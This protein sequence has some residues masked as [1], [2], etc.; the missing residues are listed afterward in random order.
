MFVAAALNRLFTTPAA[1]AAILT[2]CAISLTACTSGR[3]V[4]P[5]S[6][7]GDRYHITRA[8]LETSALPT[9]YD[10]VR[11][12]RPFWLNAGEAGVAVYLNDQLV[13]GLA[14]LRRISVHLTEEA[15]F[16]SAT[17]AQVRFGQSNG[18][19]PAI[20]VQVRR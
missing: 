13:G 18:L 11:Q 15:R 1:R 12:F 2:V 8:E 6:F 19:R 9:L 16:M 3:P 4:R 14:N 20:L 10:A 17:E 7:E 5:Q